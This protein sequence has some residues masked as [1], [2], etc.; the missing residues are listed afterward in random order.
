[1]NESSVMLCRNMLIQQ[2]CLN[3]LSEKHN[4]SHAYNICTY[5]SNSGFHELNSNMKSMM[6]AEKYTFFEIFRIYFVKM[7]AIM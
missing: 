2:N 7:H 3:I 1:M 4:T 6:T 5:T